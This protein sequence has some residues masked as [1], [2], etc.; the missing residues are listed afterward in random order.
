MAKRKH[1]GDASSSDDEAPETFSFG[2]SKKAAKSEQHAVREFHAA[3]KLKQRE[4]NRA[5]DRK[6][7][8]R[9]ADS[10][11]KGKAKDAGLSHWE[12]ATK[13]KGA[14]DYDTDEDEGSDEGAQGPGS[15]ALEERMARAMREAEE[16]DSELD[17]GSASED[18]SGEDVVMEG[19]EDSV[20][21][22]AEDEDQ[23][24][25][26]GDKEEG[27]SDEEYE[28]GED[29]DMDS[30]E[31]EEEVEEVEDEDIPSSSKP[32]KQNRNYLPDHFFK[33]AL[34]N[35]AP[36]NTKI[37]F[38]DKEDAPSRPPISPH[39]RRRTKHSAKDIV[40]G[41]RTVRTLSKTSEA[42]SPAAAK[43]L[44][45]PRRVEK[46][47][48]QSLNLKGDLNRSKTKG[49]TRRPAH[50]GVLRRNGPAAKFVRNT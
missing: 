47:V 28:E 1:S 41:T 40:L 34:F 24:L 27:S 44:P 7:K 31:Q 46:F 18:L 35:S 11:L 50:L 32:S 25:E 10:K 43:G 39:K 48:K 22:M 26:E 17:E 49:W 14:A 3:Q 29:E 20:E 36:L 13:G 37:T 16:E 19:E 6:L 9:A 12:K 38:K 23:E 45:P 2:T 5:I 4:K 30:D 8:E 21:E 42:I 15:S 33:S